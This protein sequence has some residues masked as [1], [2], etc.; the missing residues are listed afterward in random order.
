M[1][2]KE[3]KN[4]YNVHRSGKEGNRSIWKGNHRRYKRK[5]SVGE[6][7]EKHRD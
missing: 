5:N 4:T 1:G 6:P 3:K 7:K 2:K